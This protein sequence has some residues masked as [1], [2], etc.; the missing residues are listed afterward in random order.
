MLHITDQRPRLRRLS[1]DAAMIIGI[2]GCKINGEDAKYGLASLHPSFLAGG[3][4][5]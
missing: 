2:V 1:C 5:A 3:G 4:G